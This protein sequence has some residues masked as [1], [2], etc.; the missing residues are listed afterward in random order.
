[1]SAYN[2]FKDLPPWAKGVVIVGGGAALYFTGVTIYRNYKRKKDAADATQAASAAKKELVNL[3]AKGITPTLSESQFQ[4]LCEGLVQAM[5]GCGT[6]EQRVYDVFKQMK[7]D[8]DIRQLIA[9]FDL[10]YYEPCAASQ[11]ISYLHWQ[12]NDKAYGGGLPTW[13]S[14]DL[15]A[16][17]IDTVNAIL[18]A[19]KVNYSF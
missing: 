10:R 7:N 9:S 15:S 3:K 1:M 8:A 19:N 18:K 11:P 12:L 2:Y 6:D 14:Y 5:N 16:S 4:G 13:L 17:E